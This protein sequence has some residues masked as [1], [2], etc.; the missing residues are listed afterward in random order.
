MWAQKHYSHFYLVDT[1]AVPELAKIALV[2]PPWTCCV[3]GQVFHIVAISATYLV[4]KG[5]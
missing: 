2:F 4:L 3:V 1:V 5:L